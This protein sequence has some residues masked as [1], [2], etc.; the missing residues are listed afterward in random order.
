MRLLIVLAGLGL[1]LMAGPSARG[2][3]LVVLS[4]AAVRPVLE[5]VPALFAK[6]TGNKMTVS[7]GTAGAIRDKV[8]AGE[9][10]DLV[11]VPPAQIDALVKDNLLV[12]GSRADLG[13]V[14]LGAAV[15]AGAAKPDIA[16]ESSFK[17]AVLAAPS[18]AFADPK[19]GATSGIYLDKLMTQLGIAD[20]IKAKLKLYPDGTNAMEAVAR[21]EI[22]FAAGQISEA[23]PVKGVELV[24]ALP[25]SLQ[26]KTIYSAGLAAKSTAP[27]EAKTLLAF[28]AGP[29]TEALFKAAG[30]EKP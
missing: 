13:L 28:L 7:Y 9:R 16:S 17:A 10:A 29:E 24:G 23:L 11:I 30:F 19:S 8:A 4:A 3:D 27:S 20:Q 15:R 12:A 18:F 1:A 2:A 5:Q 25:D 6:A 22:A 14:R 26:L 21:G